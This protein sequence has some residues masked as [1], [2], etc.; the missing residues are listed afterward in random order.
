MVTP[1][2]QYDHRRGTTPASPGGSRN[3]VNSGNRGG[4][5]GGHMFGGGSG[6]G[7]MMGSGGPPP[8]M[9]A[10]LGPMGPMGLDPSMGM[11]PLPLPPGSPVMVRASRGA[12]RGGAC[13]LMH[14]PVLLAAA[15]A[16]HFGSCG[17]VWQQPPCAI[18]YMHVPCPPL[19]VLK[20]HV[21][22]GA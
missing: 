2:P 12:C 10:G 22:L 18:A 8:Y 17:R 7:A 19:C 9:A 13:A 6:G 14:M 4:S 21:P 16:M 3:S 20:L 15:Q 11:A 5:H 1:N